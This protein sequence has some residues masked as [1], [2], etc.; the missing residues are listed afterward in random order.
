M[1][2]LL[3]FLVPLL[4]HVSLRIRWAVGSALLAGGLVLV[5]LA[6]QWLSGTIV[7]ATGL[8]LCASAALRRPAWRSGRNAEQLQ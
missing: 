2:L 4:R 1:Y 5:F 7:A 6:G 3:P 8:L